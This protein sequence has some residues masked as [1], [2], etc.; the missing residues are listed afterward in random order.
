MT[1]IGSLLMIGLPA[2]Q[3]DDSTRQLIGQEQIN[4]FILFARNIINPAQLQQLSA[5]LAAECAANNLAPPLIAI[6]QEGGSVARLPPPWTQFPDAR[7]LAESSQPEQALTDFAKTC[8]GELRASGINLNMAPVL[9]VCPANEGYFME[10]RS[11]GADP[12]EVARLGLLLINEMQKNGVAA[13]AK[14][15]PGLG[16]ARL[17][18]HLIMPTVTRE[19]SRLINEDL[20]PFRAAIKGG[21]AAIMTSHTIYPNLDRD[22]PATLSPKILTGI[23]RD[24]LGYQGLIITDDLEMGAIE[25]EMTVAAAALRSFAAGADLLLICHDH[26]KVRATSSGFK[27]ALADGHLSRTRLEAA[28]ARTDRIRRTFPTPGKTP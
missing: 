7:L 11:L 20:L 18:P 4:N 21:V 15:F 8:A 17:D 24:E 26:D 10:R 1:N 6:D 13:C 12:D 16:A 3:L 22:N 28:V 19:R 14:H 27:Q 25:N 9:D 5:D 2:P 23:L